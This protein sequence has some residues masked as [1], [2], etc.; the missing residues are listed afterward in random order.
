MLWVLCRQKNAPPLPRRRGKPGVLWSMGSQKSQ[1]Q[2]SNWTTAA[3]VSGPL[4]TRHQQSNPPPPSCGNKK[5]LQTRPAVPWGSKWSQADT[6]WSKACIS[7][8]GVLCSLR[9]CISFSHWGR[10]LQPACIFH[11]RYSR[12]HSNSP[13]SSVCLAF[14]KQ[15]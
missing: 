13:M 9:S 5:C 4:P 8:P 3:A 15:L 14:L 2:L 11:L 7:L 6:H 12:S 10:S 1:T